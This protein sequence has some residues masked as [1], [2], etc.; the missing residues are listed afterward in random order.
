MDSQPPRAQLLKLLVCDHPNPQRQRGIAFLRFVRVCVNPSLTLRVMIKACVLARSI[1]RKAQ[2]RNFKRC[3]SGA[4]AGKPP[5]AAARE[6]LVPFL[7][8][9]LIHSV[10]A[11]LSENHIAEHT[12]ELSNTFKK[13]VS[14]T[15]DGVHLVSGNGPTL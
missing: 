14:G 11:V 4:P 3:D 9:Q 13:N 2:S 10:A 7:W 12:Y 6:K 15:G 5:K 1:N 8:A